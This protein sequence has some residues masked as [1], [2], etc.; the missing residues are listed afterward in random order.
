MWKFSLHT[1][2]TTTN[3]Y[4]SPRHRNQLSK[5]RHHPRKSNTRVVQQNKGVEEEGEIAPAKNKRVFSKSSKILKIWKKLKLSLKATLGEKSR[6]K[7]TISAQF[8][9]SKATY[10]YNA[11]E[12]GHY[13]KN[14]ISAP[15]SFTINSVSTPRGR[16][17]LLVPTCPK[18]WQKSTG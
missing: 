6:Y 16:A 5:R 15:P 3:N 9:A 10:N 2:T 11:K 18:L 17:R 1:D 7:L 13:L 8:L 4:T 14:F 12:T